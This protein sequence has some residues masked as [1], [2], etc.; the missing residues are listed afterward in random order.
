MAAFR[1]PRLYNTMSATISSSAVEPSPL[2][3]PSTSGTPTM[4][5][6]FGHS[7]TPAFNFET[8][9]PTIA[10]PL[11]PPESALGSM[12]SGRPTTS[13]SSATNC[14]ST[15]HTAPSDGTASMASPAGGAGSASSTPSSGSSS[16]AVRS[17]SAMAGSACWHRARKALDSVMSAS[18]TRLRLQALCKAGC[19]ASELKKRSSW[20]LSMAP[21]KALSMVISSMCCMRSIQSSLLPEGVAADMAS[22]AAVCLASSATLAAPCRTCMRLCSSSRSKW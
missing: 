20:M 5:K 9:S 8:A 15:D 4:Q 17:G 6:S 12:S 1:A 18:C 10:K 2:P 13:A 21:W 16:T 3:P 11:E 19:R 22:S 7:M 14:R